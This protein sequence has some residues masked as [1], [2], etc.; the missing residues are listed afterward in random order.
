MSYKTIH[1]KSCEKFSIDYSF[2][3]KTNEVTKRLEINDF[4]ESKLTISSSIFEDLPKTIKTEIKG[5]Y[6]SHIIANNRPDCFE[7]LQKINEFSVDKS[8]LTEANNNYEDIEKVPE[9]ERNGFVE[10]ISYNNTNVKIQSL[11]KSNQRSLSLF[12]F[13]TETMVLAILYLT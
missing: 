3:E 6:N 13:I 10:N 11:R 12:N 5:L 4:N 2:G 1:L 8:L 9:K 7:L